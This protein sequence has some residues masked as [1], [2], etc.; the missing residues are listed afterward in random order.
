ME[1]RKDSQK[2]REDKEM[3][4]REKMIDMEDRNWRSN[5]AITDASGD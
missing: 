3:K 4:M 2:Y 5:L 1:D